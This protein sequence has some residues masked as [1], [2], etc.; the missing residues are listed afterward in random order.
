MS[1]YKDFEYIEMSNG[2]VLTDF[3]NIGQL[4]FKSKAE[5]V[6][7]VDGYHYTQECFKMIETELRNAVER[8]PEFCDAMS[9]PAIDFQELEDAAKR[10]NSHAPYYA[11]NILAEEIYEAMN[12]YRMGDKAHCIQELAQCGAVIIRMMDFVKKEMDGKAV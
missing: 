1:A 9:N 3:T 6:A 7:Y 4:L 8:H 10:S 2:N 11:E 12:A 5:F